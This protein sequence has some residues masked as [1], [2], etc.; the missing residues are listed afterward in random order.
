MGN[1]PTQMQCRAGWVNR[2]GEGPVRDVGWGRQARNKPT[3]HW[4]YPAQAVHIV[5]WC[6]AGEEVALRRGTE[7]GCGGRGT[8][9]Q[10]R[11]PGNPRGIGG[12]GAL[13]AE[14]IRP[15]K[16]EHL[17]DFLRHALPGRADSPRIVVP[18]NAGIHHVRPV[19]QARRELAERG[20]W[21]WFLPTPARS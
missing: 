10:R 2:D 15:W 8:L 13:V 5:S 20:L 12:F 11:L 1:F 21:L 17:L 16:A 4:G 19:R 14:G 18:G 3:G 9:S 7:V 6:R